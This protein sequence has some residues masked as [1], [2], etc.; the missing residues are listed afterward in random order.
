MPVDLWVTDSA[1]ARLGIAGGSFR[2]VV[3]LFEGFDVRRLPPTDPAEA[4]LA[5]EAEVGQPFV[6]LDAAIDRA[7][8]A[9]TAPGDDEIYG[10]AGQRRS[11]LETAAMVEHLIST[12]RAQVES[13]RPRAIFGET[14]NMASRVVHRLLATQGIL[15]LNP[16]FAPYAAGR[17]YFEEALD[18]RWSRCGRVYAELVADGI[19]AETRQWAERALRSIRDDDAT[20]QFTQELFASLR[21]SRSPARTARRVGDVLRRWSSAKTTFAAGEPRALPPALVS[22][23]SAVARVLNR[24]RN[25]RYYGAVS[26]RALPSQP[27]VSFFL[28]MRPEWTVESLAFEWQDQVHTV[29]LCAASLPADHVLVVKDHPATAG[30]SSR[31]FY[32][33]LSTIPG[34]V[35]LH[36][37]VPTRDVIRRSQ[38]IV[39]LTG[40]TV[41]EAVCVSVPAVVLGSTYYE[42]FGGVTRAHT[43][44]EI[45]SA[46]AAPAALPRAGDLDA[47]RALSATHLASQPAPYPVIGASPKDIRAFAHAVLQELEDRGV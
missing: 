3:N 47:I 4:L 46:L 5:L 36:H 37:T 22:P 6:H 43:F 7:L 18:G 35:L 10:G 27:F 38:A 13:A 31:S 9:F 30:S 29:R 8:N 19:P 33:E 44:A 28:H 12:L 24:P 2:K 39:T 11:W 20:P 45:R 23:R 21:Q 25:R 32:R 17:S 15:H 16:L 14:A 1:D 41:I 26:T 34:V 42:R 40:T